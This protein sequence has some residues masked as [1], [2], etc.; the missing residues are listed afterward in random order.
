MT[1]RTQIALTPKDRFLQAAWEELR[2][3][4]EREKIFRHSDRAERAR[5]LHLPVHYLY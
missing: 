1:E 4:E 3:F 5:E 2:K